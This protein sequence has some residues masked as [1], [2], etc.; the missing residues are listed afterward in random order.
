MENLVEYKMEY[1]GY[2]IHWALIDGEHIVWAARDLR[3]SLNKLTDEDVLSGGFPKRVDY[4]SNE[5]YVMKK[6]K[7]IVDDQK[8]QDRRN[9]E[10]RM[11]LNAFEVL[12]NHAKSAF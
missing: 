10:D 11:I 6:I 7:E 8:E 1:L 9:R 3:V 2:K 5:Q 4:W 12:S